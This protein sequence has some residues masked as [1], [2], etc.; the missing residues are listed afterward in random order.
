MLIQLF[1]PYSFFLAS[2]HPIFARRTSDSTHEYA[3]TAIDLCLHCIIAGTDGAAHLTGVLTANTTS[4]I[5]GVPA[6]S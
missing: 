4:A 3:K 1:S 6:P 5:L 2:N